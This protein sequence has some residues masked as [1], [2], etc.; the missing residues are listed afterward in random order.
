MAVPLKR[1]RTRKTTCLLPKTRKDGSPERRRA[2]R[3]ACELEATCS[4]VSL[5]RNAPAWP[6]LVRDISCTG[7][8]LLLNG[9]LEVGTFLSVKLPPQCHRRRPLRACVVRIRRLGPRIWEHGCVLNPELS[10]AEIEA[11][12]Q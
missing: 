9:L 6:V 3:Y 4:A 10:K 8:N 1:S 11:L 2:Y 7:I 12:M 5:Q